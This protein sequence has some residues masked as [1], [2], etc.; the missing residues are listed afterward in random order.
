MY[1]LIRTVNR[2]ILCVCVCVFFS[3]EICLPIDLRA[4]TIFIAALSCPSRRR[5][6]LLSL[7]GARSGGRPAVR[8]VV[9]KKKTRRGATGRGA[10]KYRRPV[11]IQGPGRGD[12]ALVLARPWEKFNEKKTAAPYRAPGSDV[13]ISEN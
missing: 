11:P 2:I 4:T 5:R 12:A 10:G 1:F 3:Y 6:L 9:K 8:G 13:R 7:G